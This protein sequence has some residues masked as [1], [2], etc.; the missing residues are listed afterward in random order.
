MKKKKETKKKQKLKK[1]RVLRIHDKS[2]FK[3]LPRIF[4]ELNYTYIN[5]QYF[6]N[7]VFRERLE[8]DDQPFTCDHYFSHTSR[9]SAFQCRRMRAKYYS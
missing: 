6:L 7:F 2:V 8:E 1:K 3:L 4:L 5:I 9:P